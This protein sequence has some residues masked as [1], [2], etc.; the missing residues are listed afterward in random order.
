MDSNDTT[1]QA[2]TDIDTEMNGKE[3]S[4]SLDWNERQPSFIK[5][6]QTTNIVTTVTDTRVCL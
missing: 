3:R 6:P 5:T 2:S 1:T 4:V